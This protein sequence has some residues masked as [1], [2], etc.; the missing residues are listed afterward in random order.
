MSKFDYS[1]NHK[2]DIRILSACASFLLNKIHQS[3]KTAN[4]KGQKHG[5]KKRRVV[6]V[7]KDDIIK[8]LIDSK[9]S[10][11]RTGI[12]FY[13]FDT[14]YAYKKASSNGYNSCLLPSIDRVD[15]KK[16][17][18][19]DNIEIVISF[20]NLGKGNKNVTNA[21][22]VINLIKNKTIMKSEI[23]KGLLDYYIDCK[24]FERAEAYFES[25]YGVSVKK[26]KVITAPKNTYQKNK[27]RANELESRATKITEQQA[28]NMINLSK[29]FVNGKGYADKYKLAGSGLATQ[30]LDNPNINIY[31]AN[32][33]GSKG[34]SFYISADDYNTIK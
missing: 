10:C 1:L 14:I 6:S 32:N 15:S 9:F 30:I 22:E 7:T 16:D 8:L 3:S 31:L 18:S 13:Q 12:P 34:V 11:V 28:N 4:E 17:Y 5:R 20:Y 19:I 23:N 33:I 25:T 24:D 2:V 27:S 26:S 21:M 29:L